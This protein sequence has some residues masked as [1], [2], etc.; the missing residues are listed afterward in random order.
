MVV[1]Y[2]FLTVKRGGENTVADVLG[3]MEGVRDVALL[4]GEYDVIAKIERPTMEELQKFLVKDVRKIEG[5]DKT[6]TMIATDEKQ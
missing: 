5:V 3:A 2:V 6:S 1:A 4:Y